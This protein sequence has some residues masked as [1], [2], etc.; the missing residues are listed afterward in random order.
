[1]KHKNH[2]TRNIEIIY[3]QYKKYLNKILYEAE[4]CHYDTLFQTHKNNMK[5]S[6]EII[7]EIINKRKRQNKAKF[8]SNDGQPLS[9][10]DVAKNFNEFL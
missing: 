1:M 6:W 10:R 5:K 9:E 4:R 7:A 8:M 3:K 2:P